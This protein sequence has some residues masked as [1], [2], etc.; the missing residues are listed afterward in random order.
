MLK[1][2]LDS[3]TL[4][5]ICLVFA[6]PNILRVISNCCLHSFVFQSWYSPVCTSST[7]SV[8]SAFLTNRILLIRRW[9]KQSTSV[10]LVRHTT[11]VNNGIRNDAHGHRETGMQTPQF[12]RFVDSTVQNAIANDYICSELLIRNGRNRT[13]SAR[14]WTVERRGRTIWSQRAQG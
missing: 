5:I 8:R 1:R 10:S 9:Q 12:H 14:A 11:L 6:S 7:I 2:K 13:N 3:K 4:N